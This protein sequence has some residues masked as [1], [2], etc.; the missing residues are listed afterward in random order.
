M[1]VEEILWFRGRS[2]GS[3][4]EHLGV[5][6]AHFSNICHGRYA[7]PSRHISPLAALIGSSITEIVEAFDKVRNAFEKKVKTDE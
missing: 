3:I 1:D 6:A 7:L 5:T 2:K 4:A